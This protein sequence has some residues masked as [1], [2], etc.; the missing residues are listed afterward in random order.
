[1]GPVDMRQANRAVFGPFVLEGSLGSLGKQ[2]ARLLMFQ[3]HS[4]QW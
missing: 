2:E 3:Q 1:M 4:F